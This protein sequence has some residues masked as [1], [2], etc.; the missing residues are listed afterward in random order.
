M[1]DLDETKGMF[2]TA[3]DAVSPGWMSFCGGVG[4]L[5]FIVAVSCRVMDFNPGPLWEKSYALSLEI[6]R[7][8]HEMKVRAF[9]LENK[10]AEEIKLLKKELAA[11]KLLAHEKGK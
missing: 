2:K 3:V 7:T 9:E 4:L 1:M 10:N 11:V 5:A 8:E 6:R